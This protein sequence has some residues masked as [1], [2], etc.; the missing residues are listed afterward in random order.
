MHDLIKQIRTTIYLDRTTVIVFI[1]VASVLA[2]LVLYR[3]LYGRPG[4]QLSRPRAAGAGVL[5]A[6]LLVLPLP[7]MLMFRPGVSARE[8]VGGILYRDE[9]AVCHG[10]Q[11]NRLPDVSLGSQEFLQRL[12]DAGMQK[13]I[14]E[15]KGVMPAWGKSREGPLSDDDIQMV[16]DFLK[17][18]A[19]GGED[20]AGAGTTVT[21]SPSPS[22]PPSADNGKQ[23]FANNCA[24][25][26]GANGTRI[27]AAQLTSKAFMDA[28]D[29]ASLTS[30]ITNGRASMPGF[31]AAKGGTLS[32]GDVASIIAFLRTLAQEP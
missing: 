29:D 11:G 2:L 16:I 14:S 8:A 25:C 19:R 17:S 15:G 12:G 24:A 6:G 18:N 30:T 13:V 23:L 9:C 4:E 21:A 31:G 26:H 27:P 5:L 20:T 7:I 32:D 22:G 1:G 10:D 28:R 3:L